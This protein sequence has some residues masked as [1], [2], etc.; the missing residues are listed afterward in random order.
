MNYFGAA[1]PIFGNTSR[2]PKSK[3]VKH[4]SCDAN[5]LDKAVRHGEAWCSEHR[6]WVPADLVRGQN[7]LDGT[8]CHCPPV[9]K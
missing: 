3:K 6:H 7:R 2:N 8:D 4:E 5:D 1:P 9:R